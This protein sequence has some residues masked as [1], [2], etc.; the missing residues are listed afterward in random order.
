MKYLNNPVDKVE[1][2]NEKQVRKISVYV[3]QPI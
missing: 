3:I 2:G 1:A